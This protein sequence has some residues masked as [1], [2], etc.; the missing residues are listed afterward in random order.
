MVDTK[1]AHERVILA[2]LDKHPNWRRNGLRKAVNAVLEHD[3][4]MLDRP[5]GFVPDAFLIDAGVKRVRLLEV[6]GHSALTPHKLDLLKNLWWH[7]DGCGWFLDLT[8]IH[9]FT[10][11]KSFMDDA[12]F[13]RL[14]LRGEHAVD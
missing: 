10:G 14:C 13:V 6:D 9:L 3:E 4:D 5:L 7:L 12:D 8:T 2:F 11:A 1:T